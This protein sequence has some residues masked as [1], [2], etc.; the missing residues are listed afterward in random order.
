[1]KPVKAS[2]FFLTLLL[3]PGVS[4]VDVSVSD[5]C[6]EL[7]EPMISFN[8]GTPGTVSPGGHIGE[9]G[10]YSRQVCVQGATELTI[11]QD[12]RP[13]ENSVFSIFALDNA[14]FSKFSTF[15][16]DVC[17]EDLYADVR[18][19]C[20]TNQ[21]EVLSVFSEDDSHVGLGET[22]DQSLCLYR[23]P[24][25]NITL[26]LEGLSGQFRADNNEI[27]PGENFTLVDYPYI[28]ARDAGT[29][30]GIVSYGRFVRLSRPESDT[31]SLTQQSSS[32]LLP[33]FRGGLE[34]IED[35][36]QPVLSR[37]F[38][39]FLSPSFSHPLPEN[40]HVRVV[41]NPE[42]RL[43][44]FDGTMT[45]DIQLTLTNRGLENGEVTVSV[46]DTS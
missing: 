7:E 18:D 10:E 4:A 20:L 36:Q 42:T 24:P 12:C 22:Y 34:A 14:H 33:Y 46:E 15:R 43:E 16:Y 9:P 1:M 39:N 40:P 30:S 11:R 38:M 6:G 2:V 5:S 32:F 3:A 35:D 29:V 45:S 8:P 23:Q 19:S 41:L 37:R 17:A 25:E 21:T 28:V 26:R 44:G 31:A 13:S 27:D